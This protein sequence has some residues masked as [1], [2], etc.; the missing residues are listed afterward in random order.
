[1]AI[2]V[3]TDESTPVTVALDGQPVDAYR[4]W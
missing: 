1:M 3:R 4:Q 2:A